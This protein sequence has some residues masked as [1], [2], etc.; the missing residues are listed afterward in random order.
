MTYSANNM[1]CCGITEIKGLQKEAK[2]NPEELFEWICEKYRYNEV[3]H[4]PDSNIR[5]QA[6]RGAYI[7]TLAWG[8]DRGGLVAMT[9]DQERGPRTKTGVDKIEKDLIDFIDKYDLGILYT[10]PEVGNP[11]YQN[12]TKISI[13]TFVPDHESIM[14]LSKK[15]KWAR[16]PQGYFKRKWWISGE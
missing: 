2:F 9:Q 12:Q 6:G 3:A 8:Y 1:A 15:M 7:M 13:L 5:A 11:N 10:M 14:N 16:N 4:N